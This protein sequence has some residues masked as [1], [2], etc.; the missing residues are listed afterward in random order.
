M[1]SDQFYVKSPE[2]MQALFA[3]VPEAIANTVSVAE[4]CN[5]TFEFGKFYLPKFEVKIPRNPLRIIWSGRR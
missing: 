1:T 5:L 3:D 4:R 2:E